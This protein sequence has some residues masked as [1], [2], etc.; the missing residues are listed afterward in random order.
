MD[1]SQLIDNLRRGEEKG[2][3]AI[4]GLYKHALL[5]FSSQFV[6][7]E[8]AEEIVSDTFVKVWRLREDFDTMQKLKA[9]L[10]I[11][12]K[13]ACFNHLRRPQ[14]KWYAEEIEGWEEMLFEDA[15]VFTRIVQAEL[16]EQIYE[17]VSKLPRKQ[18]E[19]FNM[20]YL[21][22]MTVEEIG[23]KLAISPTAVYIHRSRA[24]ALLRNS[25][26]IK[27]LLYLLPF[28]FRFFG[29]I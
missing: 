23:E 8:T 13:N 4:Y 1:H 29:K 6:D 15:E 20:T 14:A 21:E 9:F 10:Y 12:A 17:E 28:L 5:Y 18:R 3:T 2:L 27:N 22:D 7:R 24:M 26:R 25:I 11:S 16:L 19:V